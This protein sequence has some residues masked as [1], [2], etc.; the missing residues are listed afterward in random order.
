MTKRVH[1]L[2]SGR[3]QGVGFR[4]A[5]KQKAEEMGIVG[6]VR[7]LPDGRVEVVLKTQKKPLKR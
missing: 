7:N 5:V 4:F 6:W 3:V 1:V 2:I